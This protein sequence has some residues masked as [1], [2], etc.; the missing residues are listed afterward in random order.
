MWHLVVNIQMYDDAKSGSQIITWR[1]CRINNITQKWRHGWKI[2]AICEQF[3]RHL[4]SFWNEIKY[5]TPLRSVQQKWNVSCLVFSWMMTPSLDH[6]LSLIFTDLYPLCTTSN[7]KMSNLQR[8]EQL[9]RKVTAMCLQIMSSLFLHRAEQKKVLC[10]K[11]NLF[12]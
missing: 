6:R 1:Y 4:A 12:V 10:I 7:R 8:C 3:V 9:T 11:S 2:N 5:N